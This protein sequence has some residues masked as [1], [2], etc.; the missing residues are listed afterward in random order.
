M[1]RF[2]FGL[3]PIVAGGVNIEWLGTVSSSVNDSLFTFVGAPYGTAAASRE[4]FALVTWNQTAARTNT[5]LTFD[6]NAAVA[7]SQFSAG[8]YSGMKLYHLAIPTGTSG[9]IVTTFG[10][11][12]TDCTIGIFRV[13][14]RATPDA[15]ATSTKSGSAAPGTSVNL[16]GLTVPS[17]GFVLS[18]GTIRATSAVISVAGLGLNLDDTVLTDFQHYYGNSGPTPGGASGSVV[19][20]YNQ[21]V[22]ALAGAYCF[23]VT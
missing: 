6:G 7:E 12:V 2:S 16:G 8:V 3:Y 15:V 22:I 18:G 14:G 4:I 1:S 5:G 10:F 17:G 20:T 11:G 13:T 9:T 19:W 23:G 21:S